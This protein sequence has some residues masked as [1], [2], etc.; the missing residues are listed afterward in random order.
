MVDPCM[1][2]LCF[3][4][5]LCFKSCRGFKRR[6]DILAKS[7]DKIAA[8]LDVISLVSKIR[9]SYD[10]IS[11]LLGQRQKELLKFQK[12][13]V[14]NVDSGSSDG[15]SSGSS[16]S[17]DE[18]ETKVK[19]PELLKK[20]FDDA[21]LHGATLRQDDK[22][23][24]AGKVK[25]MNAAVG[26][27]LRAGF[28]QQLSLKNGA[29]PKAGAPKTEM[30]LLNGELNLLMKNLGID[31]EETKESPAKG[32]G[33]SGDDA[34]LFQL[35]PPKVGEVM[36]DNSEFYNTK[37]GFN[38]A[39]T[40]VEPLK[41]TENYSGQVRELLNTK[42]PVKRSQLRARLDGQRDVKTKI[43]PDGVSSVKY[44]VPVAQKQTSFDGPGWRR[45]PNEVNIAG[46]KKID[47]QY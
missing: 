18:R 7:S 2:Y 17:N 1:Q 23:S 31:E 14:I 25:L 27:R 19:Q 38:N 4:F 21:I 28:M 39:R 37:E 20:A 10:L 34:P 11:N 3:P 8:E 47:V 41:P 9:L 44:D 15:S 43:E 40:S 24:L 26:G 6:Q 12:S 33:K 32:K 29:L 13:T 22:D 45:V 16:S 42:N 30:G 36:Q 46:G 5:A 35:S